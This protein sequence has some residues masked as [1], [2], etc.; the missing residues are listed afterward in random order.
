LAQLDNPKKTDIMETIAIDKQIIDERIMELLGII[1]KSEP[2]NDTLFSGQIGK[3][4]YYF[5]MFRYFEKEEYA[6]RGVEILSDVI[7]NMNTRKS[8]YLL[9]TAFSYGMSGLGFVIS[10]LKDEGIIE[11]D[12]EEQL[13]DF[14]D[15]VYAKA[16]EELKEKNTDFMHGSMGT[17]LYLSRRVDNPKARG[18]LEH[19]VD[20]LIET[21]IEDQ[22]GIRFENTHI[23]RLN[24]SDNTNLGL[25]H[26]LC[27]I[28]MILLK[29]HAQGVRQIAIERVVS[30][31]I[32]Y[33]LSY[34]TPQDFETGKYSYFPLT[35]NE[36]Q[37][38][39]SESN[40]KEY[41]ARLGWCYGDLNQ[42][43]VMLTA[44]KQFNRP[45]W[46]DI[47][48]E[49]GFDTMKRTLRK[50]TIVIDAHWCHGTIGIAQYYKRFYDMTSLP[51]YSEA[52]EEWIEKTFKFLDKE[53]T[54][55]LFISHAG[56]LLEGFLGISLGLISSVAKENLKWD[57]VFLMS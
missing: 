49:V 31:G 44:S 15:I 34:K 48:N 12:F 10:L 33:M 46:F 14:D 42:I 57:S 36:N 52:H 11:I 41:G 27:G 13:C 24:N 22:R 45:E 17:F 30:G 37:A 47:A 32:D 18:Y 38:W 9:K 50:E 4:L 25:A 20:S 56:E 40:L 55:P 35:I 53:T 51:M 16:L 21:A 26:G 5:Y 43:L 3:V 8:P 2:K 54:D 6:D 29:I 19:L 39:D 23:A 28:L 7:Q 1:E